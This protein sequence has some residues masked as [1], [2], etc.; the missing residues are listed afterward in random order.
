[1]LPLTCSPISSRT[2]APTLFIR[3]STFTRPSKAP[4][5]LALGGGSTMDTGKRSVYSRQERWT[6]QRL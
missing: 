4:V 1:M 5:V 3:H 6:H 2:R